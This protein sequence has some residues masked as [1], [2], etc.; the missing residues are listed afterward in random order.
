MVCG[1]TL[2]V[3]CRL[4]NKIKPGSVPKFHANTRMAFKQME[5]IGWFLEASKAFGVADTDLFMTVDLFDCANIKQVHWPPHGL[6]NAFYVALLVLSIVPLLYPAV[7]YRLSRSV[8]VVQQA[9]I[10][11]LSYVRTY[12]P[13]EFCFT[14]LYFACCSPVFPAS[15]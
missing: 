15:P 8:I 9:V 14:F 10:L 13:L 2:Q 1:V 6:T 3:L 12:V 5:N 7:C 4:M 11:L